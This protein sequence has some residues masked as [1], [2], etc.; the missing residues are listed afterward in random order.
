M[1]LRIVHTT[2]YHYSQPARE[3]INELRLTPEESARQSLEHCAIHVSPKTTLAESHDL[4]GNRLHQFTV[5]DPHETLVVTAESSVE[6]HPL[7]HQVYRCYKTPLGSPASLQEDENLHDFLSESSC[8]PRD[9]ETWRE[10]LDIQT[11]SDSTWGGLLVALR[12]HIFETCIYREQLV[13]TMRT[14]TEVQR[15]RI[16]TCQDFAHLLLAYLRLLNFP[17]RYCSGYL[18]DP[19]LD[20]KEVAELVGSGVTHAWVEAFVPEIGWVGIDPT[21][22]CWVDDR[23]VSLAIGRDYHDIVPIQGSL[24]GGGNERKLDVSV[25][26][27]A[28]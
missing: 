27:Q 5:E 2:T 13:H 28:V 23:Y 26:V 17:A 3:S 7:P 12:N 10:A 4:F 9:P 11:R 8:V 14:S 19:G 22:R 24:I 16:G 15:E 18:Y 1:R 6:T 21:N 20:G 25:R